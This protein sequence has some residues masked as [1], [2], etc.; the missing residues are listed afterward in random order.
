MPKQIAVRTAKKQGKTK[1]DSGRYLVFVSHSS[2]DAWIA[3]QMAKELKSLGAEC[4]LDQK[5]LK[6]GDQIIDTIV[7]GI[8]KCNEAVVLISST[9]VSSQWVN[10]EIGAVVILDKRVT[11][12]LNNV[13]PDAMAPMK[14]VKAIDLNTFDE[15]LKQ[16]K[17][18]I[19][20]APTKR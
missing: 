19:F 11:P 1:T 17:A 14:G 16:L 13:A 4:W 9:S 15:F 7:D 10:F 5:D 20:Q 2:C 18:R 8:R 3:H 6:G 12:I